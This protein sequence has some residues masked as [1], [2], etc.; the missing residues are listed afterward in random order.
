MK[1]QWKVHS[2]P[3]KAPQNALVRQ[4]QIK[5]GLTGDLVGG[6][7]ALALGLTECRITDPARVV[8]IYTHEPLLDWLFEQNP[9][10]QRTVSLGPTSA[11]TIRRANQE[12]AVDALHLLRDRS[13]PGRHPFKYFDPFAS[14]MHFLRSPSSRVPDRF[15]EAASDNQSPLAMSFDDVDEDA[16]DADEKD[17]EEEHYAS[18]MAA[19]EPVQNNNDTTITAADTSSS[20]GPGILPPQSKVKRPMALDDPRRFKRPLRYPPADHA[21]SMILPRVHVST[22]PNSLLRSQAE[23]FVRLLRRGLIRGKGYKMSK[24]VEKMIM[25]EQLL[26]EEE[27]KQTTSEAKDERLQYLMRGMTQF[28]LQTK[29]HSDIE[30]YERVAAWFSA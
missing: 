28:E 24:N 6:G 22:H 18:T 11:D 30:H 21:Q 4:E 10:L 25:N 9:S 14:P 5:V 16:Q 27:Q 12:E 17:M 20:N 13:F 2:A 1:T 19:T 29:N 8:G 3:N 7:L 26:H 15:A 23:E